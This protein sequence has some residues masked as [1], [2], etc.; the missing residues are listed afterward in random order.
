MVCLPIV[1]IC[2]NSE[3]FSLTVPISN[4][5]RNWYPVWEDQQQYISNQTLSDAPTMIN[6]KTSL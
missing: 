2:V 1:M 6:Y 4:P 3:S 5:A